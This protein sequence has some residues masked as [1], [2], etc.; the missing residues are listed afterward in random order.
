LQYSG[1]EHPVELDLGGDRADQIDAWNG[2]NFTLGQNYH[3]RFSLRYIGRPGVRE[4]LRHGVDD[5]P[6]L[7]NTVVF[8]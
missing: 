1:G 6:S 2:Q 4:L 3:L 7:E 5:I 8:R